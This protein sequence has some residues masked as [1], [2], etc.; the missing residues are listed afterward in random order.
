MAAAARYQCIRTCYHAF[1]RYEIGEIY[2]PS[3]AEIAGG[4]VPRHFVLEESFS[5]DAVTSA[6]EEDRKRENSRVNPKK[7]R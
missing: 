5:K 1:R 7:A 4:M 3:A 6:Q 2:I